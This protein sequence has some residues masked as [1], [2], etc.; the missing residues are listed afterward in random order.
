MA[1]TNGINVPNPGGVTSVNGQTGA[2]AV[3][4]NELI[5][6]T[7]ATPTTGQVLTWDG[8]M[9]VN[10]TAASGGATAID[11]LSDVDTSTTAPAANDF[12]MWNTATNMWVPSQLCLT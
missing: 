3:G 7:V 10:Q 2:A 11:G 5:D 4:V 9:W 6:A 8:T 1:V 12:L